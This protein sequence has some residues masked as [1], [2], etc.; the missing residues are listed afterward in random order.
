MVMTTEIKIDGEIIYEEGKERDAIVYVASGS[1][2]LHSAED[3]ESTILTFGIGTLL[4]ESCLTCG[5]VSPVRV[6]A[7]SFSVIQV[8]QK[9]DFWRIANEFVKLKHISEIH[10]LFYV[11]KTLLNLLN[12]ITD[13]YIFSSKS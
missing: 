7:A 2:H 1:V 11:L 3:Y 4:G 12:V 6:T 9:K 10:K 13:R 8:L 5:T